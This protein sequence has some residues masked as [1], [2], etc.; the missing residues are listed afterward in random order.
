MRLQTFALALAAV[1]AVVGLA[2][3]Q[4]TRAKTEPDP[5]EAKDLLRPGP[6]ITNPIVT[7]EEKPRYTA[8]AM[9]AKVQGI[10]EVEVI[11][12]PNGS[13]GAARIHKSLDK[14]FGLDAE[15][16][17]AARQWKFK[18]AL[19]KGQPVK[20]VTIVKLEYRLH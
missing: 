13:V 11:V 5:F 3:A 18:P 10:A 15:A 2:Q 16:V 9:R 12:L 20:V 1:A 8:A 7:R 6:G 14:E 4:D 19:L 17:K